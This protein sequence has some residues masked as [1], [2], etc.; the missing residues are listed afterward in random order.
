MSEQKFSIGDGVRPS[1]GSAGRVLEYREAPDERW[2][3]GVV[4]TNGDIS[5]HLE[6]SL[7]STKGMIGWT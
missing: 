3:V 6:D 4:H 2:I 5:Y 1:T 7:K